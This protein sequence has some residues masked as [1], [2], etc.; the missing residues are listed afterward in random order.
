MSA[1]ALL[2]V[3]FGLA[4]LRWRFGLRDSFPE[5]VEGEHPHERRGVAAHLKEGPSPTTQVRGGMRISASR[6]NSVGKA[7]WS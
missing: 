1:P 7:V 5:A 6:E 4:G 2:A 3:Q